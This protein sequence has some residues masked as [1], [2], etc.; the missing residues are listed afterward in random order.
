MPTFNGQPHDCHYQNC[1]TSVVTFFWI[2]KKKIN[3]I[4]K[5]DTK[6]WNQWNTEAI[7]RVNKGENR[8]R[9]GRVGGK[10]NDWSVAV[11]LIESTDSGNRDGYEMTSKHSL[12]QSQSV[13]YLLTYS[14]TWWT[15]QSRSW[16]NTHKLNIWHHYMTLERVWF[17]SYKNQHPVPVYERSICLYL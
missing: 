4:Q 15:S 17:G 16:Q 13:L 1:S 14:F 7:D 8:E 3:I 11:I 2:N 9:M 5:R 12:L 10:T 6:K